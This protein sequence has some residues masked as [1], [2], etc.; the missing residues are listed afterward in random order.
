MQRQGTP[1]LRATIVQVSD[2]HV[3]RKLGNAFSTKTEEALKPQLLEIV[4]REKPHLLIASGDQ[5]HS[6]RPWRMR[7]AAEFL[8]ELRSASPHNPEVLAIAGNHD[9]KFWFGTI[10]L[11]RFSRIPFHIYFRP[12]EPASQLTRRQRYW[13]LVLNSLRWNGKNIRDPMVVRRFD[14]LGVVVARFNSNPVYQMSAAGRVEYS[15]FQ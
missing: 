4:R 6:P 1:G 14:N 7:K 8:E 11:W 3:G 12:D 9:Y 2:L 5:V 15:D 10:G 13:R